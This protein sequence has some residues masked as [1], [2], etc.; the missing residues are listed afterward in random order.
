MG[1]FGSCFC[2]SATAAMHTVCGCGYIA[3]CYSPASRI[4][5]LVILVF[6]QTEC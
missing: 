6:V 1:M 3:C 5:P 2:G 4:D